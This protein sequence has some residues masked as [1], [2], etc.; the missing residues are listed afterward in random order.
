MIWTYLPWSRQTTTKWVMPLGLD[1]D[2]DGREGA[3][4]REQHV[5]HGEH[6]L[7]RLDAELIGHFFQCVDGGAVDIGLAGF[8][9]AAVVDVD[10]ETFEETFEG[11]GSAIHVGG[12]DRFGDEEAGF[13]LWRT[14]DA[15]VRRAVSTVAR[16]GWGLG[17]GDCERGKSLRCMRTVVG[18]VVTFSTWAL[19]VWPSLRVIWA[20]WPGWI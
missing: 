10:A 11:G 20:G 8:A 9:Q 18:S 16:W 5:I 19:I 4:F 13:H 1:H 6:D 15:G 12:L 7:L 17:T 14:N 3:R 2:G